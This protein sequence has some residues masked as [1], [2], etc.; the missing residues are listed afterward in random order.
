MPKKK[1]SPAGSKQNARA[2]A[3]GLAT[4]PELCVIGV[5]SPKQSPRRLERFI[6]AYLSSTK[7][8]LGKLGVRVRGS[9][10][11]FRQIA[12]ELRAALAEAVPVEVL[13]KNADDRLRVG[14]FAQRDPQQPR[15]HWQV[16]WNEVFLTPDGQR[17]VAR[18]AGGLPR[19]RSFRMAFYIHL[20]KHGATLS[21]SYGPMPYPDLAAVPER[22][23]RLA[24]Y[25][26]VD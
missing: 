1:T 24:P 25:E 3:A 9:D 17:A 19:R 6:K 26:L 4:E 20:W 22:L 14:D 5:Y 15:G 18:G 13:V 16:A 10:R 21:S 7:R 8:T 2:K 12:Q 11:R 23:W